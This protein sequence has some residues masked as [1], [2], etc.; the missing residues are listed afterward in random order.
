MEGV[1]ITSALQAFDELDFKGFVAEL[2]KQKIKLSL[3]QQDEWEEYFNDYQAA[4]QDLKTQIAQ[5]DNEI[6]LRVYQ[7]YGLTYEEVLAVD[8]NTAITESEFN[9]TTKR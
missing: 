2:K 1:K 7:L 6:D 3:S 9:K 4:C 8:P 5:T